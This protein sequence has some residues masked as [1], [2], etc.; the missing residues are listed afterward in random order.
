MTRL[1]LATTAPPATV[2]SSPSD[3]REI[4]ADQGVPGKGLEKPACHFLSFLSWLRPDVATV[5]EGPYRRLILVWCSSDPVPR[6]LGPGLGCLPGEVD[7]ASFPEASPLHRVD[8]AFGCLFRGG[9]GYLVP[10]RPASEVCVL[11]CK[12]L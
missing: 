6:A 3:P 11:A 8:W 7:E 4:G 1:P 2:R 9:A 5:G 10:L 12:R